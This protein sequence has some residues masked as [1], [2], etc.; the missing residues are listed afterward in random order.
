MVLEALVEAAVAVHLVDPPDRV[1][2]HAMVTA[3]DLAL[4]IDQGLVAQEVLHVALVLDLIIDLDPEAQG[5][6]RAVVLAA[7]VQVAHLLLMTEAEVLLALCVVA[8][9]GPVLTTE[10]RLR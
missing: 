10:A 4:T 8:A 1:V 5:A 3:S 9:L 7:V 6:H 2:H